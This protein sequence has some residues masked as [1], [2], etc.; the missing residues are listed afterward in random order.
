M[1]KMR[2]LLS[3]L[4]YQT[5]TLINKV[6]P[7]K[8]NNIFIYDG[9]FMRQ[10]CWA[11]FKYLIKNGFDKEYNIT[12]FVNNPVSEIDNRFQTSSFIV[13]LWKRVRAKYV[14]FEY[15]NFKLNCKRTN[16]QVSFNIWHGMPIKKIGYLSVSDVPHPY[17]DDYTYFLVTS[18]Y[19]RDT[20]KKVFHL[21]DNQVYLGGYPR[22]DYL[23]SPK[24]ECVFIRENNKNYLWMP[25]FRTSS[26]NGF[27]DSNKALPFLNQYNVNEFNKFLQEKG[28]HVIIKLHPFQDSI[29][30]LERNSLSNIT[31]IN[32]KDIF[33]EGLELY[34]LVGFVDGLITDYSS[35]YFDYLLT[36]KPIL[37]AIDDYDEYKSNRGFIDEKLFD[38]LQMPI[39]TS[40]EDFCMKLVNSMNAQEQEVYQALQ[41][42]YSITAKTGSFCKDI[43]EFVGIVK[44]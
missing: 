43:L 22:N 17:E 9:P 28:I 7:K 44:S 31:L 34:E 13:A 1:G 11:L 35:I 26:T 6:V 40:F 30:W 38:N 39:A 36:E 20:M 18:Q 23:K 29:E 25:T 32:N 12:Y 42:K 16:R 37:F 8:Q 21:S 24:R 19:F 2:T 33:E 3:E 41:E 10:N 4:L 15:N 27:S 5:I 14:F